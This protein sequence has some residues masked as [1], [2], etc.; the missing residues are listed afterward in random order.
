[1][2]IQSIEW[3]FFSSFLIISVTRLGDFWK[4]LATNFLTKVT[5][6]FGNFLGY[7][8]KHYFVSKNS[9]GSFWGIIWKIWA[10]FNPTSGHTADNPSLKMASKFLPLRKSSF[11]LSRKAENIFWPKNLLQFA[12]PKLLIHSSEQ[13]NLI[14]PMTRILKFDLNHSITLFL[15]IEWLPIHKHW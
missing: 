4:F 10:T 12:V 3:K 2:W 1:M 9:C 5:Q 15:M 11:K 8:E 13:D 6:I 14:G 7:C